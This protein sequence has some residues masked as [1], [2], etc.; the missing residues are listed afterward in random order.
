MNF[1]KN[2]K[3]SWIRYLVIGLLIVLFPSC[4]TPTS[5]PT[6]TPTLTP[7]PFAEA[8][9]VIFD[10]KECVVI[11]PSELPVGKNSFILKDLS[12][13]K[14]DIWVSL[15]SDGKTFQ[16]LVDQQNEPGEYFPKPDWVHHTSFIRGG[17]NDLVEGA[18]FTF[19]FTNEG[20]HAIYVGGY[21][22]E[23]LWFCAPIMIIEAS[24]Q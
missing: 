18:V 20:E 7:D 22:P 14:V 17:W 8:I 13:K 12:D 1:L 21:R 23:T 11:G 6:A 2:T 9:E 15:L 4:G 24:S 19:I 16:D 10:G 5:A 3:L